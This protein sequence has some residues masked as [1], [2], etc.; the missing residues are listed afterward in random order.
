MQKLLKISKLDAAKRQLETVIRM[1]FNSGDPVSIHTLAAAGYNL[2]RDINSNRGG[3][4]M[5]VKDCISEHVK[6][7]IKNY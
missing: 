1:Y 5:I 4:S 2:I 7:D 6:P 3:T